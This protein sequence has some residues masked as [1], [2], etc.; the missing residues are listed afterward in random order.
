[1]RI[2]MLGPVGIATVRNI[3]WILDRGYELIFV[4]DRDPFFP[5]NPYNLRGSA[6]ANYRF[7]PFFGDRIKVESQGYNITKSVENFTAGSRKWLGA[8]HIR[9]LVFSLQPDIIHVQAI[10]WVSECCAVAK[11]QPLVVSAWG[12]LNYLMDGVG[13][14]SE[15]HHCLV[16]Q[17][18]EVATAVIVETP[19]LLDKTQALLQP[20]QRVTL[21]P[22][23]A[24]TKRFCPATPARIAR[25]R[26]AFAIPQDAKIILSPR[27]WTSGYGQLEII[28]A[29]GLAQPD[30]DYPT[31]IV[32]LG[33]ARGGVD[34]DYKDSFDSIV[35]K[36]NLEEKIHFLPYLPYEMM[37]GAYQ[38]ADIIVN[39]PKTDAFPSTLME[40]VACEKAIISSNLPA[41]RGTFIDEFATLVEPNNSLA[42][43]SAMTEVINRPPAE[44]IESL[45]QARQAIV[46]QYEE[47]LEQQKLMQLYEQLKSKRL[48]LSY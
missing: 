44:Y 3:E 37:P 42:L 47:K 39:Y 33:L 29:Y 43:A 12:F 48:H 11:V 24:N 35:K 45:K 9:W 46:E 5:G 32:F 1:M 4:A 27:S 19:N 18:L 31:A 21:I 15:K 30:F 41:Y 40:V 38:L 20:S 14:V 17:T 13:K 28:E 2:L 16:T 6:P 10:Y 36:F 25:F 23:G 26:Q 34:R 8:I 7:I 22:L